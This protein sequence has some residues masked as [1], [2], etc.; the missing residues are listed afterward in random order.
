MIL[1]DF[2]GGPLANIVFSAVK[3]FVRVDDN[4]H[5]RVTVPCY[6]I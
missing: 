5:S 4:R 2:I 3:T 6:R 1:W